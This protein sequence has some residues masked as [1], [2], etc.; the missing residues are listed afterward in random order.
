MT[1]DLDSDEFSV[2]D[3]DSQYGEVF[4]NKLYGEGY[5]PWEWHEP[6]FERA[7]ELGIMAFS[8]PL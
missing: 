6:I 7:K 3:P 8:T 4:G 5:T 2:D 1:L